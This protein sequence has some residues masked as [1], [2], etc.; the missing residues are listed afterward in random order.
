VVVPTPFG[1][2]P[3]DHVAQVM[4]GPDLPGAALVAHVL[5]GL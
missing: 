4:R 3:I 5:M 1:S 2:F